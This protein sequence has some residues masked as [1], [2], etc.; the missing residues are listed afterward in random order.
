MQQRML[1]STLPCHTE[2][3]RALNV[4]LAKTPVTGDTLFLRVRNYQNAVGLGEKY[5]SKQNRFMEDTPLGLY[6][7]RR[8]RVRALAGCNTVT[9]NAKGKKRKR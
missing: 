9:S 8:V 5:P 6:H 7:A 2:T 3:T 1:P 4:T